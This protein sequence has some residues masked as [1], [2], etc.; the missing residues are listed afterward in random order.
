MQWFIFILDVKAVISDQKRFL[1]NDHDESF[2]ESQHL[3]QTTRRPNI[4]DL[5]LQQTMPKK[6]TA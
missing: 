5:S 2:P 1:P 6:S 3:P 4:T